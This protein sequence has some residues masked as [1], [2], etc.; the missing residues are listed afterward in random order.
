MALIVKSTK[1]RVV[2]LFIATALCLGFAFWCWY[3]V[4]YKYIGPEYQ[5]NSKKAFTRKSNEVLIPVLIVLGGVA[6]FF[7]IK[8]ARLRIEVDEQTGISVNG[9]TAIA[10]DAIEDVD[11]SALAKKGYLYIKYRKSADELATL[12]LDDYNLDFFEELYAILRSKLS[13]PEQGESQSESSAGELSSESENP[14]A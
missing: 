2:K 8:A 5:T 13:L 6:A 10:W 1:E 4:T 7:A 12:K 11:V 3:D 9:Q 14:P